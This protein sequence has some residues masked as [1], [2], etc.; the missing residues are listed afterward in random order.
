[1]LTTCAPDF[2]RCPCCRT[3]LDG[4]STCAA[5]QWSP[6]EHPPRPTTEY[7]VLDRFNRRRGVLLRVW[8]TGGRLF[9]TWA[10]VRWS[11]GTVSEIPTVV[12]EPNTPL[13]LNGA[14]I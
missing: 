12:L 4:P 6:T 1:M 7:A 10:R 13:G 2:L 11:D 3:R 14:R 8:D 5:C 9:G